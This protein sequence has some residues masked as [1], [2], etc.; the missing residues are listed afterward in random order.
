VHTLR[1]IWASPWFYALLLAAT[2]AC[3]YLALRSG[4][5]WPRLPGVSKLARAVPVGRPT[6]PRLKRALGFSAL[7][8]LAF[9]A[10]HWL[11]A[12]QTWDRYML[13][14]V[15]L[16]SLLAAVAFVSPARLISSGQGQR[17]YAAA[18]A[19]LLA[20]ALVTPVM[21]AARSELPVGGDHGAYDGIDELTAHVISI[22]PPGAVLYDHWLGY[23]YRFYLYGSA[24]RIH[25]Y[26]DLTDLLRDARVYH[27]E[28]RYIAFP[29][30][31]DNSP[32][33]QALSAAGIQAV[34]IYETRRRDGTTSFRL[35]LLEGP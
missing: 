2:V 10:L 3:L 26:P 35:Y 7:F 1:Y 30:W 27:R 23:H 5:G 25:W 29:S 12:F 14:L 15:P 6:S 20:A 8:V 31:R 17:L 11:I 9:L 13:G 22:A 33:L 34:P 4:G 18:S 24:L 32:A 28:T 19:A 21:S 16:L